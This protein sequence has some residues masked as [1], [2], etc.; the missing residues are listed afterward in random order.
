MGDYLVKNLQDVFYISVSTRLST[1]H[2][3]LLS[4]DAIMPNSN[5]KY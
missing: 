3:V 4:S 1:A 2:A 5:P